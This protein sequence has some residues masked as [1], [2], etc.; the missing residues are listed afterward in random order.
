MWQH[1]RHKKKVLGEEGVTENIKCYE[2]L[3]TNE[4]RS[5]HWIWQHAVF[6]EMDK[7]SLSGMVGLE[8]PES[9]LSR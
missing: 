6:G 2:E 1:G 9:G 4:K 8:G 7:S 3:N 5:N